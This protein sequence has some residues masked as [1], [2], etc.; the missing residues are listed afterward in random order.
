[1]LLILFIA[2]VKKV[3][4]LRGRCIFSNSHYKPMSPLFCDVDKPYKR[5]HCIK[6]NH[7]MQGIACNT[8]YLVISFHQLM[9]LVR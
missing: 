4:V 5:A 7:F 9:R 1:L 8:Y 6:A 2:T 3:A